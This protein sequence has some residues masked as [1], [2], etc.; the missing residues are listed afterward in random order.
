MSGECESTAV[1]GR[2]FITA[3]ASS[4]RVLNSSIHRTCSP[5]TFFSNVFMLRTAASQSP[6][7]CGALLG[8]VP[9]DSFTEGE[10]VDGLEIS[11]VLK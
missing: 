11:G 4:K 6:P 8:I 3:E 10:L 9:F 5:M 2:L 1:R 7:K